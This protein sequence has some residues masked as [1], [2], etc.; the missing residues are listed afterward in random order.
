MNILFDN[1]DARL[2]ERFFAEQFCYAPLVLAE[3]SMARRCLGV[4]VALRLVG[5]MAGCGSQNPCQL[6]TH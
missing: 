2:P 1:T 3:N 4:F 5:R 6:S